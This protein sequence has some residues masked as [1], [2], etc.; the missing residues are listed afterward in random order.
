MRISE[1]EK[2]LKLQHWA[3]LIKEY[4][5][6]G[7]KLKDWLCEN[8][9]SKDQYYYWRN[10]LKETIAKS[11]TPEFVAL[12]T[13]Q[14][15]S[16]FPVTPSSTQPISDSRPVAVIKVNNISVEISNEIS[17]E[18]ISRILKAVAYA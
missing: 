8:N 6:S 15:Y 3:T 14:P 5:D 17:T 12:P 18:L 7:L 16:T 1:A 4:N 2:Q 10:Q 9:I 11:I 13:Y